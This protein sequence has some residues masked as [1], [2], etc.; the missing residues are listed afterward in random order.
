M[1]FMTHTHARH[2]SLLFGTRRWSAP[3]D[4]VCVDCLRYA[5]NFTC[6]SS[7]LIPKRLSEPFAGTAKHCH[8]ISPHIVEGF[9]SLNPF[10]KN[11]SIQKFP[12]TRRH[13]P[14]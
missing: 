10:P 12:F 13:V 1:L 4:Q 7:S 6:C 3:W 14:W 8:A 11:Q 5:Q 9:C 2:A